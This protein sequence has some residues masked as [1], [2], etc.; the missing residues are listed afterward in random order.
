MDIAHIA[1]ILEILAALLGVSSF[2]GPDR[3]SRWES[4]MQAYLNARQ[5]ISKVNQKLNFLI[6]KFVHILY[7][8][9]KYFVFLFLLA[10]CIAMAW[11]LSNGKAIASLISEGGLPDRGVA[12]RFFM[13]TYTVLMPIGTII[14]ICVT[15]ALIFV[16]FL[17]SGKSLTGFTKQMVEYLAP[18][19]QVATLA[20][21]FA[22]YSFI[23]LPI[24]VTYSITLILLTPYIVAD[25]I[26]IHFQLRPVMGILTTI[27]TIVALVMEFII[28]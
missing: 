19:S 7:V 9:V 6:P 22:I 27:I 10:S 21:S 17:V 8:P 23:F 12:T 18:I 24:V 28:M 26:S 13:F 1:K 20:I 11:F 15:T 14:E 5:A 25:K 16:L 3:L 2:A 4:S